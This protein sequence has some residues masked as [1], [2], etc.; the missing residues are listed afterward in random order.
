MPDS[1]RREDAIKDASEKFRLVFEREEMQTLEALFEPKVVEG[2]LK[3]LAT[4]AIDREFSIN[5]G[6]SKRDSSDIDFRDDAQ[7]KAALLQM[8]KR[9]ITVGQ[10]MGEGRVNS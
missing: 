3:T 1:T 7:V 9:R 10:S 4:L 6:E 2:A 8:F 5:A